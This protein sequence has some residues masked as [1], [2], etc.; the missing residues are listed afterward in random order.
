MIVHKVIVW[1]RAWLLQHLGLVE[2]TAA[3]ALNRQHNGPLLWLAWELHWRLRRNL[4]SAIERE[5]GSVCASPLVRLAP[6]KSVL[7]A[8]ILDIRAR[9]GD[10]PPL[11]I[12]LN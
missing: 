10:I 9:I 6:S 4:A 12:R 3:E 7:Q 8:C 11:S 5:A 2:E 1:H